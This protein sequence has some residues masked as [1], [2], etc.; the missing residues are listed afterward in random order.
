MCSLFYLIKPYSLSLSM[1]FRTIMPVQYSSDQLIVGQKILTMGSCFAES[2]GQ[3][4]TDFKFTTQVNPFGTIYDPLS[5]ARL[6]RFALED[7]V[8]SEASYVLSQGIYTNLYAHSEISGMSREEVAL[9]IKGHLNIIKEFLATADWLFL[10]FGTANIYTYLA[11]NIEI[12]NC[13]KLPA[14]QFSRRSFSSSELLAVFVPLIKDLQAFNPNIKVVTTVSPVRHVRDGLP[15]NNLSKSILRVF[16]QDLSDHFQHVT[17]YPAYELMVDDLRDYR[18]YTDD[19]VHP[20]KMAI[21]YIWEHF[22]ESFADNDTQNFVKDWLGIRQALGHRP[23]H[24]TSS[25]H[26]AFLI[27]LSKKLRKF[28]TRIN[29][30]KEIQLVESQLVDD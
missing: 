11:A 28:A 18:F 19:L 9:K 29:V 15:E 8:P 23:F 14:S 27:S 3:K 2:I 22:I 30:E 16:A 24:P 1:D 7:E 13:H 20:S 12:A 4:L 17:Y 26:Q 5:I 21:K 25:Q 6:I 10:T